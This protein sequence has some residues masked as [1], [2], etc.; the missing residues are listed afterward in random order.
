MKDAV[1]IDINLPEILKTTTILHIDGNIWLLHLL[2]IYHV[3]GPV[4]IP[5]NIML[6][7]R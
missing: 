2:S 1:C 4:S 7:K 6:N 3:L 5:M